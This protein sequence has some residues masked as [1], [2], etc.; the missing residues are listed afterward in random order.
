MTD[1]NAIYVDSTLTIESGH[2]NKM[3]FVDGRL[4]D[5]SRYTMENN[6][7]SISREAGDY[8]SL[9]Y[10]QN[11]STTY[12][13]E[14]V[15]NDYGVVISGEDLYE[16][17]MQGLKNGY[18]MV[19]V[20]GAILSKDEYQIL[21]EESIA[22]LIIK[23]D[24]NF[25]KV[26]IYVS[27]TT[28]EFGYMSPNNRY[29][30]QQ[31]G[32]EFY[33][34]LD[35]GKWTCAKCGKINNGEEKNQIGYNRSNTM[36]FRNNK[37]LSANLIE[38]RNGST[39]I[40]MNASS[41]DKFTYYKL[42]NKTISFNFQA[43]LGITTYGPVDD[44]RVQI[45]LNYDSNVVFDDLAR[46]VVDDIR[47]GFIIAE[48]DRAGRLLVVDT[49]FDS[50]RIK[51]LTL[52][53]FSTTVYSKDEY[54]LL[55]PEA[56]NIVDYLSEYEQ[57]F[58]MLPEILRIFQ[59]VLLDEVHDEV[60]RIKNI[61]NIR[62]VDS[63][64][65]YKLLKL[66]GF[67][68]DVKKL[69]LKQ[70]TEIMDELN[71]FYRIAGTKD[72]L[73][74]FNVVQDNIK[75][76]N[77]KQLFTFHKKKEKAT[78]KRIFYYSYYL[79]D[80]HGSTTGSIG[81]TN[82]IQ[83]EKYSLIDENAGIYG[84]DTGITVTIN[85]VDPDTGAILPNGFVADTTEG[86]AAISQYPLSLRTKSTGATLNCI[87]LPYIYNYG[88]Q[89]SGD[90][91]DHEEHDILTSPYFDGEIIVDS[92]DSGGHI[93]GYHYSPMTGT[94]SYENIKEVPLK[95]LDNTS[96]LKLEVNA[97]DSDKITVETTVV[98]GE[99]DSR[100]NVG[101]WKTGNF[102]ITVGETAFYEII[103][104]GAGGSG[105]AADTTIGSTNDSPATSGY[106]GEEIKQRI[107]CTAGSTIYCSI[108]EG[109]KSSYA[110][111]HG[112]CTAGQGGNGSDS[113][114]MGYTRVQT[115]VPQHYHWWHRWHH[116]HSHELYYINNMGTR[117]T[118]VAR[119]ASGAGGGSSSFS[120]LGKKYIARG[121]DGGTA[122][123]SGKNGANVLL[124]GG[125]GGS[126]GTKTGSGAIGGVRN[127][128]DNSF[129]SQAGK[130]GYIIIRKITQDYS[131]KSRLINNQD[132]HCNVNDVFETLDKEFKFTVNAMSNGI[133]TKFTLIPSSGTKPVF[134]KDSKGN[135]ISTSKTYDLVN[136]SSYVAM[137]INQTINQYKYDVQIENFGNRYVPGQTL[138]DADNTFVIT[139]TEANENGIITKYNFYP[140]QGSENITIEKTDLIAD[141][142][143][144]A[145]I[146]INS[147]EDVSS[148]NNTER[149]YIDFYTIDDL[150]PDAY[151][152]EYRFPVLDYGYVNQ[153]S[154]GSPNPWAPADPDIDYGTV[155]SKAEN[156]IDYG[157][158]KDKI[159]G[160][161]V[162][163][164]EWTRPDGLYPTNHV[165]VEVNVLSIEDYE[166]AMERFYR[167][168]YS[169][170][171]AVLYIH[172]LITSYNFG[173]NSSATIS[174]DSSTPSSNK[175][176]LGFMTTQPFAE[177]IHTMTNDPARQGGGSNIDW[178]YNHL[179]NSNDFNESYIREHFVQD[180]EFLITECCTYF[181][182]TL[183]SALELAKKY[184][185]GATTIE[186]TNPTTPTNPE[187]P[188][189]PVT[190]INLGLIGE[191]NTKTLNFGLIPEAITS[192]DD[193]GTI[194]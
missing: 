151:R 158:V 87:S 89:L 182:I 74:F 193:L 58:V 117:D 88:I 22:L 119:A 43:M 155:S 14:K 45:P 131:S 116:H 162:E 113:G 180:D 168:F 172:R 118:V 183:N 171:S 40:T 71:E 148:Q 105:G 86:N 92:V 189:E 68:L 41:S 24:I 42:D 187:N 26:E 109:G 140:T 157:Y 95:K 77:A 115:S 66:L 51:T 50:N 137:T 11:T 135:I 2:N 8:I 44:Y 96:K 59:R 55:V 19:F 90:T 15:L 126:G 28:L 141:S 57:K 60:E 73:N 81:G 9:F 177:E 72:S 176:L 65:I 149:E 99:F 146:T 54:Y 169:L 37:L 23:N 134:T 20:D 38:T 154:P 167:Q 190:I 49:D 185:F 156:G 152:K 153:G 97:V 79:T 4:L 32:E 75:L 29:V 150:F 102:N 35:N 94:V 76:V 30:C 31:C 84:K 10:N 103:L 120:Y 170:S 27:T 85:N 100:R 124:E 47:P 160:E 128:N 165:E 13:Y 166:Q 36:V 93:T 25:H 104:S 63:Q 5:P 48:K 122:T 110:R 144:G 16:K 56:K 136:T 132:M 98:N 53:E 33:G 127:Q 69:N 34:T 82:Y 17:T 129:T 181:N 3:C 62:Q 12:Y 184:G 111:G 186:P 106:A 130:N 18:I 125:K 91:G 191:T 192:T 107:Y 78:E 108:G 133:I 70:M 123:C 179:L 1:I 21:D 173:N 39:E 61:R 161:W 145:Y 178:R 101:G 194:N 112:G 175:I 121:G 80:D 64:H 147:V 174:V 7:I 83:G 6:E 138:R 163:W 114:K 46:L 52:E 139:T 164:Y 143:S 159:K 188:E 67:S 142:G